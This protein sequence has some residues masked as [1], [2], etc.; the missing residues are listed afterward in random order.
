M[1]TLFSKEEREDKMKKISDKLIQMWQVALI[2]VIFLC[3]LALID[4]AAYR[5]NPILGLL[6]TGLTLVG[7]AFM[8]D[9]TR[10]FKGGE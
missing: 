3:G 2:P 8:L 6:I 10:D 4:Y 1:V 5:F 9:Y 7:V